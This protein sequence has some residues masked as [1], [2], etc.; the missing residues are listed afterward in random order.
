MVRCDSG[1]VLARG[2]VEAWTGMR[3]RLA[4]GRQ[5]LSKAL[6]ESDYRASRLCNTVGH[7]PSECYERLVLQLTDLT[8]L[9]ERRED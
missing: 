6:K 9:I 8:E 2:V 7:R 4:Q 1:L 5:R 3:R